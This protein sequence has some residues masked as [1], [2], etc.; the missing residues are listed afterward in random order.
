MSTA[1]LQ[2]LRAARGVAVLSGAGVSAESGI[3]TFRDAQA[4][5]WARYNPQELATPAAL[6]H[7]P[8]L[9]WKWYEHRSS[10]A[11][12]AAPNPAHSTLAALE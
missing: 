10:L 5:L 6:L 7:N 4:G 3:P 1:L 9:V 8:R 12:A 11:A 2:K